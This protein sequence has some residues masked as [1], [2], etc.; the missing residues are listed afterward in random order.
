MRAAAVS[1]L[2]GYIQYFASFWLFALQGGVAFGS[3]RH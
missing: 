1:F 3:K 2:F